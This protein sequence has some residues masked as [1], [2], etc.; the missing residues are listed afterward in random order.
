[1]RGPGLDALTAGSAAA[2]MPAA[3]PSD[4]DPDRTWVTLGAGS[5]AAG[6]TMPG[7]RRAGGGFRVDMGY[8]MEANRRARTTARAGLLGGRLH[9]LGLTTAAIGFG[10]AHSQALPPSF[11]VVVDESGLIDGGARYRAEFSGTEFAVETGGIEQA[12][13]EALDGH[14][15]V[16]LDLAGLTL[17]AA[18]DE[19]LAGAM[20]AV[21]ARGGTLFAV[22]GLSPASSDP[23]Q[24][25]LGFLLIW[26][27][28]T[29]AKETL[30]TSASTRWTGLVTAADFAP[31]LL[32]GYGLRPKGGNTGVYPGMSGRVMRAA[33]S[34]DA[35]GEL[36]RLDLMIGERY[37]LERTA[38]IVY[39]AFM[40]AVAA[41]AFVLGVWF[42]DRLYVL[43]VPGLA[44][45]LFPVG[46]L[47]APLAGTGQAREVLVAAGVAIGGALLAGRLPRTAQSLAASMLVG[48][49][50]IALDVVLGSPLT[51]Q[52]ALGFQV[53]SGSRFYGIGN[54]YV[55]VLGAMVA[56]GLGAA[57]QQSP[58]RV[59]LAVLVGTAVVLVIGGPWW[60]ANWGGYVAALAG[61]IAVWV[62]ASRGRARAAVAGVLVV[63]AGAA[64]PAALDLLRPVAERT[65]M[66]TAA[67]A[68]LGGELGMVADVVWRKLGLNWGLAVRAGWL[69]ALLPLALAAGGVHA[70]R[71]G[72]AG[73]VLSRER[74]VSAG[75]GGA[76]VTAVVAMV[77]NDSGV[78]SLATASA[79][80]LGAVV[81]IGARSR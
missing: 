68:L 11:A 45:A 49:G 69:W 57:L 81:F 76:V 27:P 35:W 62:G 74:F 52:S 33:A 3:A 23:E 51:R 79:V 70:R 32:A 7:V 34:R 72:A 75:L 22:C 36:D 54:E 44:G 73:E 67:A 43:A 18:L 1:L 47:V 63:L 80:V 14:D 42:R 48:T 9:E 20:R 64:L 24:R 2:L 46:L 58:N 55:G 26:G 30:L 29:G 21:E 6:G 39:A 28:G 66:G 15:V 5:A 16:L 59:W 53:L 77:V 12:V 17:G 4:A 10:A 56:I 19:A 38:V 40:A 61:L 71:E 31:T 25:S 65:H 60:G 8:L 78:V 41:A 37:R 13:R 50:I